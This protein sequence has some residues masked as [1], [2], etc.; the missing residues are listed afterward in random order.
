MGGLLAEQRIYG[1]WKNDDNI[2]FLNTAK[3]NSENNN[4]YIIP[5]SNIKYYRCYGDEHYYSEVSGGGGGGSSLGGAVVG[6]ILGGATGAVIGSR[7]EQN[8]VETTVRHVNNKETYV[9]FK[10]NEVEINVCF[11]GDNLYKELF[12]LIPDKDYDRVTNVIN[13]KPKAI[14][15]INS[16]ERL[17]E[18]K[19]MLDDELITQIEYEEKKKE[20]LSEF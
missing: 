8:P 17:R 2:Y 11:Y 5:I 20:I 4:Y 13:Y 6:G 1:V 16:T 9:V 14:G 19:I 7:K 3:V 18:L 12:K 10:H 15:N